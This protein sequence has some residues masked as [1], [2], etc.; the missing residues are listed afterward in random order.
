ME[1]LDEDEHF[2][3][4]PHWDELCEAEVAGYDDSERYRE[5]QCGFEALF[6]CCGQQFCERHYG[7]HLEVCP[8]QNCKWCHGTGVYS[9]PML[10][11][12]HAGPC[13]MCNP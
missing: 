6:D 10:L 11:R 12:H 3:P 13:L 5:G 4:N 1:L 8:K 2:Y 7:D 9:G